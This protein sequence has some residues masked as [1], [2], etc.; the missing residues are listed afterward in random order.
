MQWLENF[1]HGWPLIEGRLSCVG[2]A[3]GLRGPRTAMGKGIVTYGGPYEALTS[4]RGN[5]RIRK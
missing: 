3:Y 1:Q 4:S 5:T 2:N